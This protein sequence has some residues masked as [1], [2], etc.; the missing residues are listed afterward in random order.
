MVYEYKLKDFKKMLLQTFNIPE[1]AALW[2]WD[3][4]SSWDKLLDEKRLRY[5]NCLND[6]YLGLRLSPSG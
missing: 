6:Q 3:K 2:D 4:Y 5:Y 1:L